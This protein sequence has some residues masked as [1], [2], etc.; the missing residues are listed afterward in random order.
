M[1]AT[2]LA[3]GRGRGAVWRLVFL[4]SCSSPLLALVSPIDA[5]ADQLFSAHMVQHMLLL[6]LSPILGILGFTKVILRPVTRVVHDLERRAGALAHPA[7]AVLLYVGAIWAWHVP[8][9][10]RPAPSHPLIH[11]SSTSPS[12]SRGRCTGGTCSRRSGHA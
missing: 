12:C 1:R 5:L 10:L 4:G 9:R 3:A 8:G 7:F 2:A 6:D 11:V